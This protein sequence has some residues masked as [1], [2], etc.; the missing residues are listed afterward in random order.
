MK[1]I[2]PIS[3]EDLLKIPEVQRATR[4][5]N[6]ELIERRGYVPPKCK[7]FESACTI[8]ENSDRFKFT[9]DREARKQLPGIIN[10]K[11]QTITGLD[12]PEES[13]KERYCKK[14]NIGIVFSGGPAPGGHNV[15]AGLYDAAKK[16]NPETILYGFL[17]GPDGIIENEA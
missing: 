6:P 4:S 14:R 16:A 11:V 1:D 5:I 2:D 8:L 3:I 10:N 15:I 13:F 17:L 12:S 9:I 7:I